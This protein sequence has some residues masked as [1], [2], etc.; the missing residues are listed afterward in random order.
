MLVL[1]RFR[2]E[3]IVIDPS[4][5]P[6]DQQGLIVITV[7][8]FRHPNGGNTKARIGVECDSRIPVHRKEVWDAI[9]AE[10]NRPPMKGAGDE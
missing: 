9:Q 3:Q 5:C 1:S 2:Y 10:Q 7:V 4:K 6:I 8:D